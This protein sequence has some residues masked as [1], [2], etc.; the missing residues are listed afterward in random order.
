MHQ[1]GFT[2]IFFNTILLFLLVDKKLLLFIRDMKVFYILSR[3]LKEKRIIWS[4]LDSV[5]SLP[6]KNS[7]IVTDNEGMEIIKQS[8]KYQNCV[9]L[10][11]II[12]YELY[13]NFTSLILNVLRV[14]YDIHE[15]STLLVA[16]DPGQ[17]DIGIAY[18]LDNN[19]IYT[20]IVHRTEKVIGRI[21]MG[22]ASFAPVRDR[23]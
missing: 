3:K 19:L 1:V 5:D 4:S 21:N 23:G 17:K 2:V 10:Y 18:F 12:D 16:I 15:F 22:A 11:S 14:L 6:L 9:S 8:K 20:E 7:L 13:P